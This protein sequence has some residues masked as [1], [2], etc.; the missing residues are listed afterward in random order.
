LAWK[1]AREQENYRDFDAERQRHEQSHPSL[2]TEA[3]MVERNVE[4]HEHDDEDEKHH[5]AADVEDDLGDENELGP[6]LKENTGCG[7]QRCDEQ[8]GA[9]N[10]VAARH[11]QSGARH[12]HSGKEVKNDAIQ[13]KDP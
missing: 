3:D 8:D 6:K 10:G 1:A 12:G 5:N 2:Q 13:H 11:H 4:P 7:K 9:V